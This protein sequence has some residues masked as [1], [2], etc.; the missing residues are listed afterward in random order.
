MRGL[1]ERG[2]KAEGLPA[3]KSKDWVRRGTTPRRPT[4][5]R[6]RD[7]CP[8]SSLPSFSCTRRSNSAARPPTMG[9]G[10]RGLRGRAPLRASPTAPPLSGVSGVPPPG[11]AGSE[12]AKWRGGEACDESG[13]GDGLLDTGD[14]AA[15]AAFS[16]GA[17][18]PTLPLD[19]QAEILELRC[20]HEAAVVSLDYERRLRAAHEE[21]IGSLKKL[22]E[23]VLGGG[24]GGGGDPD[25]GPGQPAAVTELEGVGLKLRREVREL[26][27]IIRWGRTR[28][29]ATYLRKRP[30][31]LAE[32]DEVT[33]NTALHI[34]AQNERAD[35]LDVLLGRFGDL[36]DVNAVNHRGNTALHM[37]V[38]YGLTDV[39]KVLL[40]FGASHEVVNNDG[41]P[42][43]RGL[44]GM[45]GETS[46]RD[47]DAASRK[48]QMASV[49]SL[50]SQGGARGSSADR[51]SRYHPASSPGSAI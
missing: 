47:I 45:M 34:A 35:Y 3:A 37:A 41:H 26:H 15:A 19:A 24:G 36:V 4:R 30:Q 20:S 50:S 27:A 39:K 40:D 21:E 25:S 31:R 43:I 17:G 14:D 7:G 33:G 44:S 48:A 23:S 12:A 2:G 9:S 8:C 11:E 42:A 51:D 1:E 22:V 29:L 32:A 13:F 5:E 16:S 10:T 38:E 49:W 6:P 28:D 18:R 46:R